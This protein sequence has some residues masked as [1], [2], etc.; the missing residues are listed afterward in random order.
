MTLILLSLSS[1]HNL[2]ANFVFLCFEGTRE[3]RHFSAYAYV[4]VWIYAGTMRGFML[5]IQS[6]HLLDSFF[7]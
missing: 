2:N 6:A 4:G 3:R 1:L 5:L 7:L